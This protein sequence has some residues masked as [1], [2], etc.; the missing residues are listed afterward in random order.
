[1]PQ[2]PQARDVGT[3]FIGVADTPRVRPGPLADALGNVEQGL[4]AYGEAL[5]RKDDEEGR[6]WAAKTITEARGKYNQAILDAQNSGEDLNGYTPKLTQQLQSDLAAARKAAPN[7]YA[8]KYLDMAATDFTVDVT[9]A[10]KM[11]EARYGVTKRV[12]DTESI[13]NENRNQAFSNPALFPKVYAETKTLVDGLSLPIEAKARLQDQVRGLASSAVQGMIEN[14]NPYEAAKLLKGGHWNSYLD[15]DHLASLT[16]QAESEIKRREA[17]AKANAAQARAENYQDAVDLIQSDITSRQQT[18]KPVIT[19]ANIATVRA[20]LTDKQFEKYQ[21]ARA[22]ADAVFKATDGFRSTPSNEIMSSVEKLKPTGGET[23]FAD[24]QAAYQAA[25]TLANQVI[26]ARNSD[27]GRAARDAFPAVQQAWQNF[28]KDPSQPGNL[29]VAIKRTLAAQEALGSKA[30]PMPNDLAIRIAADI[31][32][33]PPEKAVAKLK[34]WQEQF[35]PYWNKAFYQMSNHLDAHMRVAATIDDPKEAATLIE[36]TRA[37]DP[38]A[39]GIE[40]IRKANGVKA[41]EQGIAFAVA[42]DDRMKSLATSLSQRAGGQALSSQ[43]VSS[44][45]ALALGRMSQRGEDQ[46]TATEA[47]IKTV[48]GDKYN[49]GTVG[50]RTFRIPKGVDETAVEAGAQH[51]VMNL[52]PE[53]L[54]LPRDIPGAAVAE[55]AKA[56]V[57]ALRRNSFWVTN[58]DET[59]AILYNERGVPVTVKGKPIERTWAQLGE[60][61]PPDL[62]SEAAYYGITEKPTH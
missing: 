8:S 6:I 28:E 52:K 24:R 14:G 62:P 33:A 44:V 25:A 31:K 41:G 56:Y 16:N 18:G 59:G 45:E 20:G 32:S 51:V 10:A 60:G 50:S 2:L 38:K 40:A 53:V 15:A 49:F 13:I 30:S 29:Q 4:G 17:E 43:I 57:S 42:N 23:D 3:A 48:I 39:G 61:V 21:S 37:A 46:T 9:G 12:T 27:P 26:S 54:D 1:M 7:A 22:K 34:S 58:D 19:D 5:Q 47:A 36:T 11:A 55:T 35:G